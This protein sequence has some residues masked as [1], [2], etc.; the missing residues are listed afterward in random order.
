MQYGHLWKIH[1]PT[2][3]TTNVWEYIELRIDIEP[4]FKSCQISSM[5]KKA[6]SKIPLKPKAPF[7]WVFMEIIPSIAP[8]SLTSD[9]TFSNY[10][11]S[12]MSTLK[13]QNFMAWRKSQ[14]KKL[15]IIRICSNPDLKK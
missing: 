6:R 2:G 15:W 4:F 1:I 14:Q 12:L 3:Y 8:R 11:L 9:T 13:L 10:L 7:K 5:T